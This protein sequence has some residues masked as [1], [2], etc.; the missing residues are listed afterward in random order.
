M[1]ALEVKIKD[2]MLTTKDVVEELLRESSKLDPAYDELA[3]AF[4]C[5]GRARR[6]L[7]ERPETT[8]EA[9]VG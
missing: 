8:A 3:T 7:R 1:K 2:A 5:L 6:I 9:L 4:A